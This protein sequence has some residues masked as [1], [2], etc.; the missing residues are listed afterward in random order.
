MLLVCSW[1]LAL[2]GVLGCSDGDRNAAGSEQKNVPVR[3][4]GRH[5]RENRCSSSPTTPI[6]VGVFM[7]GRGRRGERLDAGIS[8][9]CEVTEL[10]KYTASLRPMVVNWFYRCFGAYEKGAP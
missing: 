1:L 8:V 4:S 9:T 2:G 5:G 6:E 3:V 7:F 10:K